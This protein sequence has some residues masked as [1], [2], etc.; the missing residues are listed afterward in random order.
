MR[1]GWGLGGE[2]RVKVI[3]EIGR[4]A[5]RKITTDVRGT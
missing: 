1:I 4:D 5:L 2:R 3:L